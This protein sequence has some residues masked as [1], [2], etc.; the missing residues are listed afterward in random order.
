MA[1]PRK[2]REQFADDGAYAA[3][4]RQLE[5]SAANVARRKASDPVRFNAVNAASQARWRE[6]HPDLEKSRHVAAYQRH[7]EKR[8]AWGRAY[9]ITN[10]ER[11]RAYHR[12]YNARK[13]AEKLAAQ[14][15][16]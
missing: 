10:R 5:T 2:T 12:A 1:R 4:I 15:A 9:A 14:L 7:R 6:K 3:Y 8:L 11:I 16:S 13:R